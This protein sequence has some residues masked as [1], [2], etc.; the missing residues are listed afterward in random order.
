[1]RDFI[2]LWGGATNECAT[3][4]GNVYVSVLNRPASATDIAGWQSALGAGSSLHDVRVACATCPEATNDIQGLYQSLYGRAA[5][6]TD[7]SW[8][9]TQLINGWSLV[10]LR[11]YE[12]SNAEEVADLRALYQSLFDRAANN[13]D[14]PPP[15][16]PGR[17]R[18]WPLAG[19]GPR[20]ARPRPPAPKRSPT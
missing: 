15:P 1:M 18:R 3:A 5:N 14:Q 6:D 8:S 11:A 13:A 4:I 12:A 19:A 9:R 2:A 17:R 16:P 20:G 10:Q 7:L